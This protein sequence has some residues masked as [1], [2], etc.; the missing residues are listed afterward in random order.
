VGRQAEADVDSEC[1]TG[2]LQKLKAKRRQ[3]SEKIGFVHGGVDW[4][5]A[6]TR[7]GETNKALAGAL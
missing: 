3:H 4:C 2:G 7:R 1:Q 5:E 6:E